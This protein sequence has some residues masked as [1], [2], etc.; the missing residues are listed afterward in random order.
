MMFLLWYT[1][2]DIENIIS[3]ERYLE[4]S[5]V[6]NITTTCQKSNQQC[7]GTNNLEVIYA[8]STSAQ[9]YYFVVESKNLL[10][11]KAKGD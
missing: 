7:T 2:I 6:K 3:T 8:E 10:N 1:F 9:K 5:I 4:P 11:D